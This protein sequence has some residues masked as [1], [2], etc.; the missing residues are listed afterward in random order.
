MSSSD[1]GDANN[2]S[3]NDPCAGVT[4]SGHGT[5]AAS[6]GAATCTCAP[7]FHA[8]GLF[9]LSNDAPADLC[10]GLVMDTA[11]HPMSALAKPNVGAAVTDPEFKTTVRRITD[12]GSGAF[13]PMYSPVQPWNADESYL[14]LYKVGHGHV[15]FNGKTY[16][17]IRDV[18][19]SPPD[20]EQVYWSTTDPDVLYW[21]DKN[22]LKRYRVS[23]DA[24]DV[25]H[26]IACGGQLG[27]DSHGWSSWDSNT[28][29]L[30][31]QG[32]QLL[33]RVDTGTILGTKSLG[34][35]GAP[36]IAA[37]G[38]LAYYEGKVV[39][40][41]LNVL[42]TLDLATFDEHSTMSMLE[43]GHDTYNTI[44]FDAKTADKNG[45]LV[46]LDMTNGSYRVIIGPS[47]GYPYPPTG[48][49]FSGNLYKRPGWLFVSVIGDISGAKLLDQEILLVNTNVDHHVC[50]V[51]HHRSVGGS[52]DQSRGDYWAEPHV[53]GS[54]TGTRAI[55]GSDWG[56][57]TVDTYVVELPS[58]KP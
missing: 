20:V 42:R 15:L 44:Q 1:G 43:S 10:D 22:Q 48:T 32:S 3:S 17:Q 14:L 4:C 9:C 30:Q 8:A 51:A 49:H 31:C 21:I 27:G 50:R 56:G 7:G 52:K 33:Y 18:N 46:T 54:P 16:K 41:Q 6:N 28:L 11:A 13:V 25:V 12:V 5:C 38:K 19:I 35:T 37:S 26:S 47:T 36:I 29:A 39:D 58:Y 55:F 23:T 24:S 34:G 57:T 53:S 40:P 2:P 45:T